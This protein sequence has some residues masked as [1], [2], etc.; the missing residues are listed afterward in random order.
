MA[1]SALQDGVSAIIEVNPNRTPLLQF[2]KRS[3][4]RG[5]YA[6]TNQEPI[7]ASA[8]QNRAARKIH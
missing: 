8:R 1:R 2:L 7:D 3:N 4:S 5:E 6:S